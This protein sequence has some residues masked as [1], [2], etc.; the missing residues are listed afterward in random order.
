MLDKVQVRRVFGQEE[1]LGADLP[2]GAAD[3]LAPVIVHDDHLARLERGTR[4]CRDPS[5][6]H[7]AIDG[8]SK[9][10]GAWTPLRP[11]AATELTAIPN[12][13]VCGR[14]CKIG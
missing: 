6:E 5:E 9:S 4:L 10:R 2:D 7:L 13:V 11:S 12:Q 1:K 8:P 14:F 3:S